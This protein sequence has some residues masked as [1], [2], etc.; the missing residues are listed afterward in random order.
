MSKEQLMINAQTDLN[1]AVH[2]MNMQE[3]T[4]LQGARCD[5]Q[6]IVDCLGSGIDSMLKTKIAYKAKITRNKK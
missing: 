5:D 2:A 4:N 6:Y 3:S 1:R